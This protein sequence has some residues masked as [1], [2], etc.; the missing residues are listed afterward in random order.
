M[1]DYDFEPRQAP[2]VYLKLKERG[3]KVTVRIA[4]VP[5]REPKVWKEGGKTPMSSEQVLTLRQDDWV[6]IFREPDYN[7]T[8]S[9]HWKVLDR[10]SNTAKIFS[11]TPGIY[12]NIKKYAQ[13]DE[14]GDPTEYDIQIERTEAPGLN[15]YAVTPL[16]RKEILSQ[17]ELKLL[18]ELDMKEKLPAAR[19]LTEKQIDYISEADSD[20][21]NPVSNEPTVV[22]NLE[23]EEITLEEL[24]LPPDFLT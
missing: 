2:S 14:W 5:Y 20:L 3:D 1:S 10:G 15:Y 8:E 13:M 21:E 12:K 11:G 17:K 24:N 23:G 7:V 16:P 18:S 19:K 4:S 22:R 9:F 6:T